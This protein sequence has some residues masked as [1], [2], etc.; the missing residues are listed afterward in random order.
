[1][2]AKLGWSCIK[3]KCRIIVESSN[4]SP[5]QLPIAYRFIASTIFKTARETGVIKIS[6]QTAVSKEK[7]YFFHSAMRYNTSSVSRMISR[8]SFILKSSY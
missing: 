7:E 6:P 4:A 8:W 3:L 2:H 5:I 1:M